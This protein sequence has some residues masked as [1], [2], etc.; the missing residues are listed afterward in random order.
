MTTR[1]TDQEW[2]S[3]IASTEK[4]VRT[5][6]T[7]IS[8]AVPPIDSP[9][10]AQTIDHTLL[11]LDATKAQIDDLCSEARVAGFASVCVRPNYTQQAVNNVKGSVVKVAVVVGFHTGE[12]DLSE[13]MAE[14]RHAVSHGATE[15]DVVVNRTHLQAGEYGKVYN[16]LAALRSVAPHPVLLKLILETSQLN[17]SEIIAAA[18]LARAASFDFIKTS[19]GFCGHGATV[20]H[21][22]LMSA[23]CEVLGEAAVG[24][25]A[26][27]GLLAEY[28]NLVTEAGVA[29][30][31]PATPIDENGPPRTK[32]LVHKMQ[33]KASGGIRTLDDAVK[34]LEAGATRLGTSG[35]V[36]I[37]KE[38]QEKAE[39][40]VAK[41]VNGNTSEYAN[42]SNLRQ[43]PPHND[44]HDRYE[45]FTTSTRLP[46]G[47]AAFEYIPAATTD[48]PSSSSDT[49]SHPLRRT[50]RRDDQRRPRHQRSQSLDS[51]SQLQ[52]Q[53]RQY[54]ESVSDS[55]RLNPHP[56]VRVGRRTAS[57][58]LYAVEDA[59]RGPR[60]FTSDPLEENAQMSDLTGSGNAR[61][62]NGTSRGSGPV[63]VTQQGSS[64]SVRTPRDIMKDRNERE[65][66]RRVEQQ[67]LD[68][69]KEERRR[70]A[71]RRAIAAAAGVTPLT[72]TSQR[73]PTSG[74]DQGQ[75]VPQRVDPIASGRTPMRTAQQAYPTPS[76]GATVDEPQPLGRTRGTSARTSEEPRPA[77]SARRPVPST[78][79]RQ[80][81][82]PTPAAAQQSSNTANATQPRANASSFPHAF[83]RWE[84]LSSHWEGL[85]SYWLHKLESNQ[86]AIARNVPSASAMSRQ[87]TDLSAAG[88]NLFHAVVEL[89]R[90]RASSERKFQRW[91][92]ETRTEQE[93][94][95]ERIAELERSL[96][97]ERE[98]R[99]ETKRDSEDARRERERS[100]KM[101]REIRRELN[102]S[103]EEARRAWEELGRRE[104]E[105]RERTM[106]LKEGMP[107]VV[108]GVQVVPM[109]ASQSA[110]VS[111]QGSQS[112]RPETRD[113]RYP[114]SQDGRTAYT[115]S[116]AG[117]YA[118]GTAQEYGDYYD[119]DRPRSAN[120][121]PFSDG[122]EGGPTLHH[123]PDMPSLSTREPQGTATT[124]APY[125]EGSTPATSG[126]VTTAVPARPAPLASNPGQ[127][128]GTTRA[129]Q[130]A[131]LIG[132]GTAFDPRDP[133]G[134]E[135][136][137]SPERFYQQ[138]PR[139][140]LLHEKPQA[141]VQRPQASISQNIAEDEGRL[142]SPDAASRAARELRSEPSYV[143]SVL[144]TEGTEYE[145][146]ERGQLRRDEDG[147][148]LVY[149]HGRGESGEGTVGRRIPTADEGRA[150]GQATSGLA[151]V[152]EG[153][154][155][156]V[157][158]S[159]ASDDYDVQAD[160]EREQAY[161]ERYGRAY[162][163]DRDRYVGVEAP[164][165]PSALGART[166]YSTTAATTA[167]APS[168]SGYTYGAGGEVYEDV[169]ATGS[170]PVA[171][172]AG[173]GRAQNTMAPPP[174][175]SASQGQGGWETLQTRHH[176]PTRL[177]DVIEEEEGSV[178]GSVRASR[179]G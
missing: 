68:L 42:V 125:V 45:T 65:A 123:E 143:S 167:P 63:P 156:A 34:M 146:D 113:G 87:I 151:A 176:H 104:Q 160:V 41:S 14:T 67:Q 168:A 91:F 85:T 48:R 25:W 75:S 76:T 109:H 15:L 134:A 149:R 33:V 37:I 95:R 92:F 103:K 115:T 144:S 59:L 140:A 161:R 175:P 174:P 55:G 64:S 110:G 172:G 16:E 46:S 49:S 39:G 30:E 27:N 53:T 66:R 118:P 138:P 44:P 112:Q 114:V 3:I 126:S 100:D 22:R 12:N 101:L 124:Y 57:A 9:Q 155:S 157:E 97:A 13:K 170:Q 162:E 81:S 136:D 102:I 119:D 52:E 177:S 8:K 169:P 164:S 158:G 24:G 139:S 88:A 128:T 18:V 47:P 71:E 84:Q 58:I 86:D 179:A 72:A 54:P 74:A 56:A 135:R 154:R 121:D 178:R 141:V 83:E 43:R 105:E 171:S 80:S 32:T 111:R 69:D 19:T 10:L 129:G 98:N 94:D 5:A 150:A 38:A 163:G 7:Q 108:G 21:V 70:S 11:K 173:R 106:S 17:D 120:T 152:R 78:G 133:T 50:V 148:P 29:I 127:R 145:I 60:Q 79:I 159:E 166:A 2:S 36:W 51:G 153:R 93:K 28:K 131:A 77:T 122:R 117:R 165:P 73:R 116:E 130:T 90:L 62:S 61:A 99:E 40:R 132:A 89:Q 96:K 4:V 107:T 35:G 1:Y 6:I 137:S 23:C 20:E 82:A 142:A 26:G 147:R 31:Q